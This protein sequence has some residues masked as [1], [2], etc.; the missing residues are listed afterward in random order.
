MK[1]RRSGIEYAYACRRVK[2]NEKDKT[3]GNHN[4]RKYIRLTYIQI[5][6]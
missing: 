5:D 4:I 1:S 3:K 6:R 2:E